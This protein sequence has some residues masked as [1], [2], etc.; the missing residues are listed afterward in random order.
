MRK[1][2]ITQARRDWAKV[3]RLAEKGTPV[4][5]TK[6]GT[7]IAAVVP[8]E[9]YEAIKP[10][11]TLGQMIREWR[12]TIDPRDLEGPDPWADVRDRSPPRDFNF[13]D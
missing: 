8:M 11:Q 2:T 13:E 10:K 7:P 5:I 6:R 9:Q 1:M 4:V 12:A 3:L